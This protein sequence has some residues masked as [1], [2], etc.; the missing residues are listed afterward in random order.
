MQRGVQQPFCSR[1]GIPLHLT[2]SARLRQGFE[3]RKT[4]LVCPIGK[5]SQ[6]TL[7]KSEADACGQASCSRSGR[8]FLQRREPRR[9]ALPT[10]ERLALSGLAAVLPAPA[11]LYVQVKAAGDGRD[12]AGPT[13]DVRTALKP[14][15]RN[16]YAPATR[17]SFPSSCIAAHHK[18]Q[19]S[20][21]G[22]PGAFRA[23]FWAMGGR[24]ET[25]A[26]GRHRATLTG[27]FRAMGE[28]VEALCRRCAGERRFLR[29]CRN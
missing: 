13:D 28:G 4:P 16:R 24:W 14:T 27:A 9:T 25:W 20:R 2:L 22:Q 12:V 10:V 29:I 7:A 3:S 18:Q 23:T 19:H 1:S 26:S 11:K 17:P 5:K 15:R 21:P 8:R 6:K